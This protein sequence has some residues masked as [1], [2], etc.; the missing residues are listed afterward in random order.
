LA[1]EEAAMNICS[2]AYPQASGEVEVAVRREGGHVVVDLADWG[3]PFDP[4]AAEE[5]DVA[6]Y[7]REGRTGGFGIKLIRGFADGVSHRREGGRNT[8]TLTFS[9]GERG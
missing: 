3:I 5:P 9:R 2:Y 4:L 1:V 8:L 7:L 6:R